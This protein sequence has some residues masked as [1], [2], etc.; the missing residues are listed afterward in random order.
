MKLFALISVAAANWNGQSE[1][2][3]CGMQI[4]GD[5]M[6]NATCTVSGSSIGSVFA[7]NG[8]FITGANT[9]TGFDGISGN[10]DV[11]VFFEQDCSSG[12]CDNSTCWDAAVSCV[13]NGAASAGVFF[14]ESVN[15]NRMAKGYNVNLQ[16]AGVSAGD[17]LSFQLNSD[18]GG[19]ACQNIT[20]PFGQVAA[21]PAGDNWYSDD[22]AFTVTVGDG[23]FGDLFQVSVTQQPG[24]TGNLNLWA[25]SVSN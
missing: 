13:D 9:F 3:S 18:N 11:V 12:T 2:N 23:P 6:V 22:G 1:D 8:A 17:T 15:D 7:G 24:E 5:S 25:S 20:A 10:A 21:T 14:M 16:I 19:W 4:S